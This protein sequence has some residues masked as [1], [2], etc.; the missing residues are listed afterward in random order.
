[1]GQKEWLYPLQSQEEDKSGREAV[2]IQYNNFQLLR[3]LSAGR[4][5]E[6]NK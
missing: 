1:M 6:I 5:G 4:Y 2:D 3:H